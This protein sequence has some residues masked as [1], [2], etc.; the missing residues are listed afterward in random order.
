MKRFCVERGLE[1]AHIYP[2][3]RGVSGLLLN[4]PVLQQML[5]DLESGRVKADAV[6]VYDVDRLSRGSIT[7]F[8]SLVKRLRDAGVELI[9]AKE[10]DLTM[11]EDDDLTLTITAWSRRQYVIRVAEDVA[12]TM[13]LLASKGKPTGRRPPYG[14]KRAIVN[15]AGKTVGVLDDNQRLKPGPNDTIKYL[16]LDEEKLAVVR[17]IYNLALQGR[18]FRSIALTLNKDGIPSP[19]GGRWCPGTIRSILTNPLY[20]G[21]YVYNRHTEGKLVQIKEG[22]PVKR[23][24]RLAGKK[25]KN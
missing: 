3:E 19:N 24:T 9:S 10:P 21:V 14:F 15:S 7:E 13:T 6:L 23:P 5:E 16:P 12:R 8:L 25:R 18:G 2:P 22:R 17:R 1:I 20:A 11:R 4:R